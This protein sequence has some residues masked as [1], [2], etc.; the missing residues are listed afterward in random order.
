MRY[1]ALIVE[2]T[3]TLKDACSVKPLDK[4]HAMP[5]RTL[6]YRGGGAGI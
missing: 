4:D 1:I 5:F 6:D 3:L 2:K